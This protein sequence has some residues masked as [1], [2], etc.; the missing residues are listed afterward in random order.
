MTYEA[1]FAIAGQSEVLLRGFKNGATGN[2]TQKKYSDFMPVSL[3]A[4]IVPH[5]ERM[6]QF[7]TQESVDSLH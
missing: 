6:S 7:H 5:I 3:N 2:D 1:M 4:W